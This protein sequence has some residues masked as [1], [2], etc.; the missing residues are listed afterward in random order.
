M[1]KL[2]DEGSVA[3]PK[4]HRLSQDFVSE[5]QEML[6]HLVG[7]YGQS[8]RVPVVR[9]CLLQNARSS[10]SEPMCQQFLH[11]SK[12]WFPHPKKKRD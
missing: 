1:N 12:C 11:F 7:R 5:S 4:V 8:T 6:L 10:T 9:T 2:G 3:G